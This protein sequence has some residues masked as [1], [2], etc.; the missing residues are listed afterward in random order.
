[1]FFELVLDVGERKLGA[2]HGD[3]QLGQDRGQ[4]ADVVFVTVCEQDG[5][6][7]IAVFEKIADVRDD[8]VNPEQ[9]GFGEHETGVD[10]NDVVAPT[11]GHAVH[12]EF[13]EAA[14]RYDM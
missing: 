8:D 9:F 5:A 10:D 12:A 2:V 7:M 3:V 13:A 11:N 4:S 1:M 14:K 6:N